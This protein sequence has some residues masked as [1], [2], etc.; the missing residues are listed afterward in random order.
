[1]HS[2][3][4]TAIGLTGLE[5]SDLGELGVAPAVIAAVTK[6]FG[7]IIGFFKKLKLK[8]Q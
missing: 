3:G 4:A 8:K 2:R 7:V 6:A 5:G 1:M